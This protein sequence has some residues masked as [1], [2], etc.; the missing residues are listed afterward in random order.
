MFKTNKQN[1]IPSFA[2]K[3]KY[4]FVS[5]VI[6]VKY[7]KIINLICLGLSLRI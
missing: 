1:Y 5:A 3:N 6:N 7:F 2:N 4:F